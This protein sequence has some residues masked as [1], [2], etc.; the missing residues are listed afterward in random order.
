MRRLDAFLAEY[1]RTHRHPLNLR[2][3]KVCVPLIALSTIGL[4]WCIPLGAWLGLGGRAA[5]W[6]N[7]ATIALLPVMLFYATLSLSVFAV[8]ALFFG[9]SLALVAGADLAGLPLLPLSAVVWVASWL[10]QFIGHR[11]E[12]A[13][14]AFL[15]DLVFLLIGPVFILA[16]WLPIAGRRHSAVA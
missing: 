9:M 5:F 14:P 8:M 10:A 7:G 12:G 15:D 2:I 1:G 3:H 16:T 6:I 11:I 13:K 4:L